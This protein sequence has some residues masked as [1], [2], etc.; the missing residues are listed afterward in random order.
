MNF[1]MT[2]GISLVVLVTFFSLDKHAKKKYG[3]KNY[4]KKK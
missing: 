2:F 3:N 4:K 1:L